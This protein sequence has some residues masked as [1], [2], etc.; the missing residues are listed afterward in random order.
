MRTLNGKTFMSLREHNP[1]RDPPLKA[2]L[3]AKVLVQEQ[4]I[5]SPGESRKDIHVCPSDN[6]R[7]GGKFVSLVELF[8]V[9]C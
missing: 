1:R 3:S 5:R 9:H 6:S 2:L 7:T 4:R 8:K